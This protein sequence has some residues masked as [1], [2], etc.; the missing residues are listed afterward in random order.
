MPTVVHL[1]V[2]QLFSAVGFNEN[3]ECPGKHTYGNFFVKHYVMPET[4][5][6][7]GQI[8]PNFYHVNFEK[9]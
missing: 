5:H 8:F 3:I 6:A 9:T 7:N 2:G 1:A 4:N